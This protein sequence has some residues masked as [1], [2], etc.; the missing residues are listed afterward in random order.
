MRVIFKNDEL[1]ELYTIPFENLKGKQRFALEIIKQFR[2]KVL[3]LI[4][5]QSS[6]E[7]RQFKGLNFEKL[8]GDLQDFYSIRLNQQYRL[9]FQI[10]EIAEN[11]VVI[12]EI[13][14][15]EISKHYE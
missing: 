6:V 1:F 4:N 5:V 9:I 3:I 13:Q 8:K 10:S 7:L 14:I 12:E 11:E 15:N 2:K